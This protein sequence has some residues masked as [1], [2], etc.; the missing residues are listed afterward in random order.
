MLTSNNDVVQLFNSSDFTTILSGK[1]VNN[2]IMN[3]LF[4]NET[5]F[6]LSFYNGDLLLLNVDW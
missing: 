5:H 4:F 6:V 1:F 3:N 2:G